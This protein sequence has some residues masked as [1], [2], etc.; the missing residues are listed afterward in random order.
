MLLNLT[1][2]IPLNVAASVEISKSAPFTSQT[3]LGSKPFRFERST[4]YRWVW[5]SF[6][7]R[8][9]KLHP[10]I[11]SPLSFINSFSIALISFTCI[12][13]LISLV[14]SISLICCILFDLCLLVG[15]FCLEA[16]WISPSGSFCSYPAESAACPTETTQ[17]LNII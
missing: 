6:W 17:N 4:K 11:I 2:V 3:S 14:V 10:R 1:L 8:K 5:L 9:S 13:V 15:G 7:F 16:F 12:V